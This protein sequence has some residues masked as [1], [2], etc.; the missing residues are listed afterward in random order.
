[1]KAY[2]RILAFLFAAFAALSVYSKEALAQSGGRTHS[3]SFGVGLTTANQ[4]DTNALIEAAASTAKDLTSAYEFFGQYMYRFSG[5]KFGLVVRPS[6]FTQSGSGSCTGG[7]C[8][9][10]LTALSLMTML[11]VVPLE[12]SFIKF[13]VQGGVGWGQIKGDY[14]QGSANIKFTGQN[15]GFQGGLGADF[16]FTANSC[17]TVEGNIRYLPIERSTADS[18]SGS[19]SGISQ[20]STGAEVEHNGNDMT[21]TLSGIQ[22]TIAYTFGF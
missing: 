9:Y 14:S 1:M 17:V 18:A 10:K 4:K 22:G 19:L 16:C 20:G 21:T 11:R 7:N 8:D 12:S 6:Y 15:F 2:Y 5:S 3:F 13:F